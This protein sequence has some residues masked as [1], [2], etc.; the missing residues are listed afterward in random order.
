VYINSLEKL[1]VISFAL[2]IEIMFTCSLAS[3][4]IY[5]KSYLKR[6]KKS[7]KIMKLM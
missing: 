2:I 4:E 1:F 6:D 7:K 5:K 3:R